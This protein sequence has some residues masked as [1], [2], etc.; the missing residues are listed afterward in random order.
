[1]KS[2]FLLFLGMARSAANVGLTFP[3]TNDDNNSSVLR[4]M[5]HKLTTSTQKQSIVSRTNMEGMTTPYVLLGGCIPSKL[6]ASN[7]IIDS[8]W[9]TSRTSSDGTVYIIQEADGNIAV[10]SSDSQEVLCESGIY[11]TEN[12][13]AKY[14]TI[15][16]GDGHLITW[17]GE[18]TFK[19]GH[20]WETGVIGTSDDGDAY[21]L[22][23]NCDGGISIY[24]GSEDYPGP[25]LW[26]CPTPQW[27]ESPESESPTTSLV[28]TFC[29][30]ADAPYSESERQ[31]LETQMRTMND[32]CEF[33]VHLG[34]IRSA[35]A[36]DDCVQET[37]TNASLVMRQS[38]KPVFMVVGGKAIST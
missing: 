24:H 11:R 31:E 32:E 6:M 33:V 34:D 17:L 29:I 2:L 22:G 14:W 12:S 16:Q 20:I 36:I 13:Y 28:T 25:I 27:N 1:M 35:L 21:F 3:E 26:T 37:Y 9:Q 38:P 7:D 5:T 18:P 4:V 23:T 8:T 10:R 19:D 15:L 30:V